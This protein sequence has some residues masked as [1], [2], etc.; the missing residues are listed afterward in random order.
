MPLTSA[1]RAFEDRTEPEDHAEPEDPLGPRD[2]AGLM[3]AVD[4]SRTSLGPREG[5]P[6][7]LKRYVSM[8]LEMPTP[9]IIFWGADQTQLYNDGYGVIMGPRHPRHFGSTYRECWPE[10]YPVIYPWM[11]KVLEG[12]PTQVERS[13]FTLTRHGFAE[14]AYF[15]FTLSPL[16]DDTGAIAGI[17]QPVVEVTQEV[18]GERRAATLRTLTLPAATENAAQDVLGTL[19]TNPQDVPF[20]LFYGPP[21]SGLRSDPGGL[22]LIAC[23]GL[24][25]EHAPSA[26]PALVLAALASREP[27]TCAAAALLGEHTH[28][29]TW[30]E[31][32]R[33]A[34]V[35]PLT[36]PG[37]RAARGVVVFGVSP[38]LRFDERYRDLFLSIARELGAGLDAQSA[39][40]AQQ[41]LFERVEA[42]RAAADAERRRLH[43]I[44][45]QAPVAVT[46]LAGSSYVIEM[47]NPLMCRLWGRSP[48]EV[49]G[50]AIFQAL[51]EV[52]GQGLEALL[53]GVRASRE[54]YVGTERPLRIRTAPD[55]GLEDRYFNFVYEPFVDASGQVAAVIAVATDVTV[56]VRARQAAEQLASA[57]DAARRDAEQA[58]DAAEQANRSK[59]EFLA[60]LGHELRNPLAP[61]FT[62]LELLRLRGEGDATREHGVIERQARHLAGLVD[63]LLDVSRITSGKIEL[64]RR[65]VE[66]TEVVAKAVETASPLLE[67]RHHE[68]RLEVGRGLAVHGDLARLTQVLANLLTNAA[69]YT[70][71]GG[72]IVIDARR[73][74]AE[75]VLTVRDSGRGI[76]QEML[77]RIFELFV[78]EPQNLDRAAGGLGLGLALVKSLVALHGGSVAA[79]SEGHGRGSAFEV[80]LP[81][82]A[83]DAPGAQASAPTGAAA[84]SSR[85]EPAGPQAGARQVLIVDD[86]EDAASLLAETLG[87]LGYACTVAHD[88]PR[89]LQLAART[90]FDAALLD[91][92]LPAMDGYEVA[93]HLRTLPAWHDVPLVAI[94]GYGQRSD[95]DRTRAAG[96]DHHLVKPV[97]M[98]ALTSLLATELD[99]ATGRPPS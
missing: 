2:C 83:D 18:L 57:L 66:L 15:T 17:L 39:R 23:V 59:D 98:R 85:Q 93:G 26:A 84:G 16:R 52:A 12:E 86:N 87:L 49:L 25:L 6:L 10:T 14:E 27:V 78:Q 67:T 9:A 69:K 81:A 35:V 43:S 44:F 58:R 21:A 72:R 13:L 1:D 24:A 47:A 80:R 94:T 56:H 90:R 91:L 68:L 79:R 20:A 96:F 36:R 19:D 45:A 31:P 4:W 76:S 50:A 3:R 41:E 33:E 46:I 42:A 30:G 82:A 62:A 77:P 8:I 53:D 11:Q 32:T 5:W 38:R 28:V 65:R 99:P 29:G 64:D 89:A 95:R 51:P 37:S 63:D 48:G 61:I 40:L 34:F 7:S 60:M 71:P 88:G 55:G 73:E 92:G 75:V 97:D 22:P 74:G 70:D 54:A